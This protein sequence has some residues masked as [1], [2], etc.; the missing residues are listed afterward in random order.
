MVL[1]GLFVVTIYGV[2]AILS[3]SVKIDI[4]YSASAS[5]AFCILF[6]KLLRRHGAVGD[7]VCYDR[8]VCYLLPY[9]CIGSYFYPCYRAVYKLVRSDRIIRHM[10]VLDAARNYRGIPYRGYL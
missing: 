2:Y 4:L 1:F 7:L 3:Q 9:D 6:G 10:P 5:R 8:S